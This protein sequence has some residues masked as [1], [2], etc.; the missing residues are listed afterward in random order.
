ML[1]EDKAEILWWKL[2]KNFD[3]YIVG[4]YKRKL[5]NKI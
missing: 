4:T 5:N 2:Q 1:I 3:K